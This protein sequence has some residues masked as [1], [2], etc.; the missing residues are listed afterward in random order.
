MVPCVCERERVAERAPYG[1]VRVC[2]CVCVCVWLIG[3]AGDR[4]HLHGRDGEVLDDVDARAG[5]S[6]L[7]EHRARQQDW[8]R[9]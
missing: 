8:Q 9:Q 5:A 6:H 3:G 1:A 7:A 4:G 2:V